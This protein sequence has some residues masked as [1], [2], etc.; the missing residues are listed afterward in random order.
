M[1]Q[2]FKN[3]LDKPLKI[4]NINLFRAVFRVN[5]LSIY[6]FLPANQREKPNCVYSMNVRLK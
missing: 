4:N 2:R 5:F 6:I 1:I 3:N